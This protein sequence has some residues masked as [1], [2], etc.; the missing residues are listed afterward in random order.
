MQVRNRILIGKGQTFSAASDTVSQYNWRDVEINSTPNEI[1]NHDT[2][3]R[4]FK[5][6]ENNEFVRTV[7]WHFFD[8]LL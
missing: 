3:S 5:N 4:T 2:D 1:A 6:I 8:T 7:V